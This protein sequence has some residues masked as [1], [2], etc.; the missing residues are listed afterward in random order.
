MGQAPSAI[1][2]VAGAYGKPELVDRQGNRDLEFNVAHS[3]GWVLIGVARGLSVGIDVERVRDFPGLEE[4][5]SRWFASGEAK[6][7]LGLPSRQRV[8]AF[9]ALWTL[10]EA[11]HKALGVGLHAPLDRFRFPT[12]ATVAAEPRSEVPMSQVPGV[13]HEGVTWSV[14]NLAVEEGYAAA[15]AVDRSGVRPVVRFWTGSGGDEW[16]T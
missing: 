11:C 13:R 3:G 4:I 14:W 1:G 9:F 16:P 7:I 8:S 12:A 2:L 15:V 10:K 5:V 6:E